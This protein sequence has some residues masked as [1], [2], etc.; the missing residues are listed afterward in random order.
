LAFLFIGIKD[1]QTRCLSSLLQLLI[2]GDE[3]GL[4]ITLCETAL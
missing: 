2:C 4:I 1:D 3:D